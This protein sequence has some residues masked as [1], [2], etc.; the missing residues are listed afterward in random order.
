M[1]CAKCGSA[2][3]ALAC[4]LLISATW[5]AAP[6]EPQG[7][8]LAGERLRV[9]VSSDIGGS[10]EDDIQSMIHFLMY[11]DRFDVEGLVSSPP[12][13]GRAADILK[14]ID[15]YE[16]DYPK[17]LARS[18]S[19]PRPDFLRSI[20]KQGS[21]GGW[22]AGDT[23]PTEGSR[24]I[25]ERAQY[26]DPRPLWVLVWGAISDVAQA[27]KDDPSIKDRIRVYFIASWNRRQDPV[28][29][30]YL[31]QNHPDLWMIVSDV[32]FRGWYQGGDQA[33]DLGNESFIR[34]HIQ[35]SGALGEHFAPLKGGSIKMGDTPS[36]TYLLR[37]TPDDPTAPSWGGSYRPHPDGTRKTWWVDHDR[38]SLDGGDP[39]ETVNRYREQYLRDWQR[40]LQ[41]LREADK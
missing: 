31:D 39:R 4:L 9:L 18:G 14:V 33:G 29:F 26:D 12:H 8:A 17:L 19:F 32:T 1:N 41:W 13:R 30:Q 24:W 38:R 15:V 20:T 2:V 5:A 35:G 3:A 23:G 22:Q 40:R 7:G 34:Q 25:I 36:V 21:T 37:G 10:D 16:N 6:P 27:V 11:S 28:A